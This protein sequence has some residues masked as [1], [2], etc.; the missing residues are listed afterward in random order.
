[1]IE[2]MELPPLIER[3]STRPIGPRSVGWDW[4]VVGITLPTWIVGFSASTLAQQERPGAWLPVV[5]VALVAA[6]AGAAMVTTESMLARWTGTR[7]S[8]RR[9]LAAYAMIGSALGV[10]TAV[11]IHWA[12]LVDPMPPQARIISYAALAAWAAVVLGLFLEGRLRVQVLRAAMVERA[13]SVALGPQGQRALIDSLRQTIQREATEELEPALD[14]VRA[15]LGGQDGPGEAAPSLQ[16]EAAHVLHGVSQASVRS[17]SHR[18]DAAAEAEMP[19]ISVWRAVVGIAH[20]QPFRP[21]AVSAI[22]LL[23]FLPVRWKE[24]GLAQAL[25]ESAGGVAAIAV[26]MGGANLAM[27][28]YPRLHPH[29]FIA[30]TIALPLPVALQALT[31]SGGPP[32]HG[33]LLFTVDIALSILLVMLTSGFGSWQKSQTDALLTFADELDDQRIAQLV[34]AQVIAVLTRQAA[35]TL[36]GSVQAQLVACALAIDRAVEADDPRLY[37]EALDRAIRILHE[38]WPVE[39]PTST[40]GTLAQEIEAAVDPWSGLATIRVDVG[41]DAA[42]V[43]DSDQGPWA[44]EVAS[45]VE[46]AVSNA[47]RHGQADTILVSISLADVAGSASVVTRVADDGR[48]PQ[49]G[50][51]GL[52]SA[53]FDQVTEG[54]WTLALGPGGRGAVLEAHLPLHAPGNR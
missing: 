7:R 47:V 28:R 39:A 44:T 49:G 42:E 6:L 4:L 34:E 48:G 51:A 52:G 40:I 11:G 37:A 30:T 43:I 13:A 53:Q 5:A 29:I 20:H 17:L 54:Q 18:L 25:V 16:N 35:R 38:P 36:H 27:R 45:V 8:M 2:P 24:A 9:F 33:L 21:L 46:E 32:W 14:Q 23:T 31:T 15:Y 50:R 12:G 19:R 22:Y 10:V 1:M 41:D 3:I 26:I